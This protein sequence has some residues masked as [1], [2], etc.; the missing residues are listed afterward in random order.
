LIDTNTKDA[1]TKVFRK[2]LPF[3]MFLTF[4]KF[5]GA[6]HY[7]LMSPLGEKVLPLWTVGLL[8]G[9][10]SVIQL[11]LDV[12]A[13]RILD[14]YGYRRFL[15]VTTFIFLLAAICFIFGFDKSIYLASLA[16]SAA[17]WQFYGPGINAYIL[18]QAPK[19]HAG[20]FISLRDVFASIG[21]VLSSA[22]LPFI[23]LVSPEQMGY[24]LS[25]L[26][27]AA[28]VL[29]FL[30]PKDHVSVHKEQKLSTHHHYIKSHGLA[31]S[32]RAFKRLNPASGILVML[33]MSGAI[34][35]GAIWFVVPL[36]IAHQAGSGLLGIGLGM[37][38]FA[39]VVL[40]FLLGNLA[41]RS[42]KQVLVFL[43]LLLFSIAGML[44]GFNFGWVFLIL[45]FLATAGDEMAGI[46]LWSWMHALDKDHSS[47]G[48][49]AGIINFF[50]DAGWAIGPIMAGILY[51][52]IG[53][54]WTILAA[55]VPIFL[56]WIIY[57]MVT[58]TSAW[59][60]VNAGMI[61]DKPHRR[62]HKN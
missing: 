6:L 43:G 58:R 54:S 56:T 3:W 31:D 25:G 42:N 27:I 16:I 20:K 33:D 7:S 18:S 53:P 29:I 28:L 40:G 44:L 57:Q 47:D 15:K 62:R 51:E 23:L 26:F 9:G 48:A 30:S 1:L 46:S 37:F 13:G 11:L 41:D 32:F 38:D 60:L 61:P 52:L 34:F 8:V 50:E 2:F 14:K 35:Y 24:V 36:V 19:E 39:V 21:V 49:V 59:G 17:G 5:A 12:P 22:A 55:A 45:G 10:C 4:F